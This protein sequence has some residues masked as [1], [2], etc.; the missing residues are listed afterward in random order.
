MYDFRR[1]VTTLCAVAGLALICGHAK[2]W[3][4]SEVRSHVATID[5]DRLG[6]AL[7]TE[8]LTVAVR[9]GPLP[10]F[11]LSGVDLDAEPLPGASVSSVANSKAQLA[12]TPLLLDKRVLYFPRIAAKFKSRLRCISRSG[13]VCRE[14]IRIPNHV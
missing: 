10:G 6:K 4:E 8:E 2:A 5:V 13:M 1:Q 3:V 7:V 14:S 9:G 11:E 12:A